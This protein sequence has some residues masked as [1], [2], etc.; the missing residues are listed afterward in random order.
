MTSDLPYWS[1]EFRLLRQQPALLS[2]RD[3]SGQ[4]P[5]DLVRRSFAPPELPLLL[6]KTAPVAVHQESLV[7]TIAGMFAVDA[8]LLVSLYMCIL[9]CPHTQTSFLLPVAV[10]CF[11]EG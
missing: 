5:L 10:P 7:G 9:L 11:E 8:V 4:T 6:Q 2:L 1:T 3:A